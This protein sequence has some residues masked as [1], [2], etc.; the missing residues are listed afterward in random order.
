[1]KTAASSAS[2][3]LSYHNVTPG[4]SAETHNPAKDTILAAAGDRSADE[5]KTASTTDEMD[6][7]PSTTGATINAVTNPAIVENEIFV[8]LNPIAA[9]EDEAT[10]SPKIN[11]TPGVSSPTYTTLTV[12]DAMTSSSTYPRAEEI[13]TGGPTTSHVFEEHTTSTITTSHTFELEHTTVISSST[14]PPGQTTDEMSLPIVPSTDMSITDYVPSIASETG[15]LPE[16][17]TPTHATN[18]H[19]HSSEK[20]PSSIV[21]Y[22][23]MSINLLFGIIQFCFQIL[24]TNQREF[25]KTFPSNCNR[26]TCDYYISIQTNTE[27]PHYLDFVMEAS[28][29]GWIAIGFSSTPGMVGFFDFFMSTN[30]V[31]F[32]VM[33]MSWPVLSTPTQKVLPFWTPIIWLEDMTMLKTLFRL[34]TSFT[35]SLC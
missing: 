26:T 3:R 23:I 20:C 19:M 10:T 6:T 31:L 25:I 15:I 5:I 18:K 7:A 24:G 22:I 21:S 16:G 29:Q 9:S 30:C 33:L 35:N 32:S 14:Q 34:Q 28:A 2:I 17:N 27:N 13:K 11:Q 1:M 8:T 12:D 4:T